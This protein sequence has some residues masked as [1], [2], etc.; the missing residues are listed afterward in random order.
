M[1][2]AIRLVAHW[3]KAF[4]NV[5]KGQG[6]F[7]GNVPPEVLD[8]RN[9]L[10]NEEGEETIVGLQT[11]NL[12][13]TVDG[14]LDTIWVLAGT[15]TTLGLNYEEH[16]R[17]HAARIIAYQLRQLHDTLTRRDTTAASWDSRICQEIMQLEL[18]LRGLL[19]IL[20]VD[21]KDAFVEVF[22]SNMSKLGEDGKPLR[23]E[24]GK[25]LKGPNFFKPNLE[26]FITVHLHDELT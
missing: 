5:V 25:I 14:A 13:E 1:R 24:D 12:L 11:K 9:K 21:Y 23:R 17:T 26:P 19:A 3:E 7:D 6:T 15:I 8:F 22:K 4:E 10:H 16:W 20:R 18:T 2:H